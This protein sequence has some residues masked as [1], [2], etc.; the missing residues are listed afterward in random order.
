MWFCD[1]EIDV[2]GRFFILFKDWFLLCMVV[3]WDCLDGVDFGKE[4]LNVCLFL[5]CEVWLLLESFKKEVGVKLIFLERILF[6]EKG[7]RDKLLL[8]IEVILLYL[9]EKENIWF[10]EENELI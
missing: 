9:L 5:V 1:I 4:K 7:I 3:S 10:I 6:F 2:F 8:F